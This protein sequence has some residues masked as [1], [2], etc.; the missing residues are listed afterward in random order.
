MNYIIL[1]YLSLFFFNFFFGGGG[2]GGG[3]QKY[4]YFWGHED[5]VDNFRGSRQNWTSLRGLFYVFL[6]SFLKV[7]VQNENIFAGQKF[8][9]FFG[10]LDIPDTFWRQTVDA[11]PNPTDV[12]KERVSPHT[13]TLPLGHSQ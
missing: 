4:P 1:F 3:V 2:G 10:V 13:H 6:G 5:F 8:Q 11:G 12:E 7:N 9:I